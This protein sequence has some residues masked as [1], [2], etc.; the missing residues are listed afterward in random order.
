MSKIM[1]TRDTLVEMAQKC[2][3]ASTRRSGTPILDD[4]A[5]LLEQAGFYVAELEGRLSQWE[6]LGRVVRDNL[7]PIRER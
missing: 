6:R 4:A 3:A 2:A 5:E 7:P 1:V